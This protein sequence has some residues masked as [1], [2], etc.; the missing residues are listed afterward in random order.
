MNTVTLTD[1][2]SH[3][4]G[5]LTRV[6]RGE[7]F[8]VLRHGRPIAEIAPFEQKDSSFPSWKKQALRLSAKGAGLSSAILEERTHEDVS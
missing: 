5:M 7:T 8:V 2:R 3:A 1:F 4:S 6:E